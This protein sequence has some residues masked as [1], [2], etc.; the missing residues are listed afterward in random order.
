MTTREFCFSSFCNL[1]GSFVLA[2]LKQ[3]GVKEKHCNDAVSL[4][5]ESQGQKRALKSHVS[6]ATVCATKPTF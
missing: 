1:K 4:Q 3:T 5:E 6:A 2:L